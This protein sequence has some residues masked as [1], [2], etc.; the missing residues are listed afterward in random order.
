MAVKVKKNIF[1]D[2]I[3]LKTLSNFLKFRRLIEPIKIYRTKPRL[4]NLVNFRQSYD[5]LCSKNVLK[6]A[7][8]TNAH[9]GGI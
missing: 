8:L 9:S 7:D 3:F 2:H 1:F 5:E 4:F 6:M